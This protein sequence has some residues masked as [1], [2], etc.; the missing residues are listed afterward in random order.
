MTWPASNATW[1]REKI[2]KTRARDRDTDELLAQAG[3]TV[4]RV[5]EHEMAS[6]AADR[7]ESVLR[8]AD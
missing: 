5:W 7:V 3:W 2:A 8:K 6:C 1:W 4:V